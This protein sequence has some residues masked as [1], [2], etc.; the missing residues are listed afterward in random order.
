M[1]YTITFL[2]WKQLVVQ[3][4]DQTVGKNMLSRETYTDVLLTAMTIVLLVKAYREYNPQHPLVP[5][6]M[7]SRFNEYIFSYLRL[8]LKGSPNFTALTAKVHLRNLMTQLRGEAVSDVKFPQFKRGYTRGVGRTDFAAGQ[9]L[10][11]LSDDEIGQELDAG[12][13]ECKAHF[14]EPFGNGDTHY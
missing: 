14:S 4:K 13:Q 6:R 9:Q 2:S 12:R 11:L 8:Q 1:G 3:S 5:R 7:S 10:Y